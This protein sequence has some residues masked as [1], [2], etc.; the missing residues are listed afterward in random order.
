MVSPALETVAV[1]PRAARPPVAPRPRA[2]TPRPRLYRE[3][4]ST[5]RSRAA[6]ATAALLVLGA[7]SGLTL[8]VYWA[9]AR[10]MVTER[11]ALPPE[12]ARYY[13]GE[14]VTRYLRHERRHRLKLAA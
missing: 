13:R 7:L 8:A 9:W 5:G 14:V 12:W 1:P 6:V 10:P 2:R 3:A 4:P 11:V